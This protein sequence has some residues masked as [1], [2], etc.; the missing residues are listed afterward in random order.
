M[1]ARAFPCGAPI[2]YVR[3]A[4][5]VLSAAQVLLIGRIGRNPTQAVGIPVPVHNAVAGTAISFASIVRSVF[6]RTRLLC[7]M[8]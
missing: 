4:S 5:A 2:V 8:L 7:L 6:S 1:C 3:V